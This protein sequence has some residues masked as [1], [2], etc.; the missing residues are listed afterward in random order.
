[1][2]GRPLP[3]LPQGV[4]KRAWI[5]VYAVPGE[6]RTDILGMAPSRLGPTLVEPTVDGQRLVDDPQ[7]DPSKAGP[8][9]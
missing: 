8:A 4:R 6:G 3:P 7:S 1:M 2:V 9:P 5:D